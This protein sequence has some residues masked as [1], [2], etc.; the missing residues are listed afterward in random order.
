MRDAA[1]SI[2]LAIDKNQAYSN[3]LLSE[4]IKRHK[5]E[6]KDRALLTEITYGTLQY[7]M[8]LDYYLEPLFV[9]LWIIG[10]VGFYDY[11]YTKYI[12]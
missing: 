9:A 10:C 12:I 3:L 7:K 5:I 6:A 2:L 1:L 11:L 8:T 4:T